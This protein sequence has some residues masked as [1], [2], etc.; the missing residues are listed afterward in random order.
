MSRACARSWRPRARRVSAAD[1]A[2]SARGRRCARAPCCAGDA[3]CGRSFTAVRASTR[4]C[5]RPASCRAGRWRRTSSGASAAGV[6]CAAT[7]S[8]IGEPC[9]PHRRRRLWCAGLGVARCGAGA[10]YRA[11]VTAGATPRSPRWRRRCGRTPSIVGGERSE[12][13]GLMRAVPGLLVK[14]GAESVY[15][16]ALPDGRAVARQDRRR[17]VPGWPGRAGRGAA[18]LGAATSPGVDAAALD[19]GASSRC[20]ATASPSGGSALSSADAA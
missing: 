12:V 7:E 19:R 6:R 15:V 20:S 4:R 10:A 3:P 9:P 5:S 1:H 16:A 11:A 14:D 18:A 17:R 13:T 2:G 8:V